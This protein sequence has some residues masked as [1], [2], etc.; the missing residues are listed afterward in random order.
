M[1]EKKITKDMTIS[2]VLNKYPETILVFSKFNI[3]CAGCFAAAFEK[4][5]D[6]ARVHGTDV[7]ELLKELNDII[8]K[9]K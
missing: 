3:G 8:K 1:T 9:K 2:E 7:K 6:I 4:I 5:E